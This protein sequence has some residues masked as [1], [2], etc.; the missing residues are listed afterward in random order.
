MVRLAKPG[1][2]G[3][4]KHAWTVCFDD[5]ASFVD[6]NFSHNFSFSDTVVAECDGV[7]ASNMQ[8]MPHRI[9]L[10][11]MEYDIN[12]VSGVATLPEFRMRG[13]VRE[14][15]TFAFPEMLRRHQ[16]ISL[17]VPFNYGFYEKFGY[18][19][20]YEKTYRFADSIP[21]EGLATARIWA[22][23]LTARL[24]RIYLRA[25]ES[26]DGYVLRT[27][28]T[29]QRI[30]EDLLILSKGRILFHHT[31]GTKDGYALITAGNGSGWELH[32]VCGPCGLSLREETKPFAMA[33][34][35]DPQRIL[36]DLA[37][38]F[39]GDLRLK[40]TDGNLPENNMNLRLANGQALP[41]E[42]YDSEVDIRYLAQLVFGFAEDFTGTG[43]FSQTEPYLNMI[44]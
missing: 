11:G 35:L 1:D 14:M 10:R 20:C 18:K 34:I 37:K 7:P 6:W 31:D 25:M 32:E 13:L 39:S 19:Q 9:K 26:K 33:R 36:G 40:I 23:E 5:A 41:C 22:P 24:D 38:H 27:Q 15:F 29:W 28:E 44:F 17:L 16:P 43:L 2:L 21:A 42:G 4:L 30:L 12:Y 3:F 8:L